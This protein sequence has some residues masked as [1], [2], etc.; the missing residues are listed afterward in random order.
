MLITGASA[1]LGEGFARLYAAHGWDL[2]LTARRAERLEAL[3]AELRARHG[4]QVLTIPMDL[5]KAGAPDR[6]VDAVEVG[7]RHVDG[8]IN[9]A[10]YSLTGGFLSLSPEQHAGMLAVMA[11]APVALSRRVA[12]GMVQRG[13]G[14]ILNVASL[15]GFLPATGG[16]TL[17]GPLKS[18]LIK[19]SQGLH[20]ELKGSGVHV[21]ALCPGYTRTEFHDANGS[22]ESVSRAYPRWM[23]MDAE[24]V[25]RAGYEACE[26]NRP[27]EIPGAFNRFMSIAARITPTGW[28]LKMADRHA[29]RLARM[30]R[31]RPDQT[32]GGGPNLPA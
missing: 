6:L 20:L 10:G 3:A 12:P 8:L 1:G 17:Y 14:R 4:A 26:A 29:R 13:F 31:S 5:A 11:T 23:W 32:G 15:A 25:I 2:A 27:V 19:A 18:F 16:D 28:A 22:R 30:P 24:P 7:G 9:N 21:T